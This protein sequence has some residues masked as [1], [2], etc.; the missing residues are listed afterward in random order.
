M[1]IVKLGDICEIINGKDLHSNFSLNK[2]LTKI[3]TIMPYAKTSCFINGIQKKPCFYVKL[4]Y[5]ND[6][7]VPKLVV[8]KDDLIISKACNIGEPSFIIFNNTAIYRALTLLKPNQKKILK[9]YLYYYLIKNNNYFQ[10]NSGGTTIKHFSLNVLQKFPI[11]LVSI[12]NQ[13]S[14]I[15]IIEPF[16]DL[17]KLILSKIKKLKEITEIIINHKHI[18]IGLFLKNKISFNKGINFKKEMLNA[19]LEGRKTVSRLPVNSSE[20]PYS[21]GDIL[22]VREDFYQDNGEIKFTSHM[23]ILEEVKV[24]KK[25]LMHL[26]KKDSRLTLEVISVKKERVQDITEE[27]AMREGV[28]PLSSD[29]MFYNVYFPVGNKNGLRCCNSAIESFKTLWEVFN[30]TFKKNWLHANFS[31]TLG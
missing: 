15:D 28:E 24:N 21:V 16:E 10:I 22:W 19:L 31:E 25:S 7:N 23:H 8:N 26:S 5:I 11:D 14:I 13:Q 1:E 9:K 3:K 12:E 29:P 20:A 27:Q 2:I 17:N 30:I 6:K 4:K 18:E